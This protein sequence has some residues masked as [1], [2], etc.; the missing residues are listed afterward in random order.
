V[1]ISRRTAL[2]G[3]AAAAGAGAL[4]LGGSS[5][6]A[7]AAA[8][9][10]QA[11]VRER[12]SAGLPSPQTVSSWI[13]LVNSRFGPQR[14]TGDDNHRRFVNWLDDQLSSAGFRVERDTYTFQRWSADARRDVSAWVQLSGSRERRPLD[15]LSPFAYSGSTRSTGPVTGRALYVPVGNG[16]LAQAV[17]ALL[18]AP[19]ADLAD[20]VVVLESPCQDSP[21]STVWGVDPGGLPLSAPHLSTPYQWFN[22]LG[23]TYA[24]LA[25]HCR[26]L[27]YCWTNVSDERARWVYAPPSMA[28][29][30]ATIPA[31]WVGAGTAATLR[32]LSAQGATIGIRLDAQVYPHTATDTLIATLPGASDEVMAIGSHTDGVNI[33]EENGA[34]AVLALGLQAARVP[35]AHRPRSLALYLAT[36]HFAGAALTDPSTATGPYGKLGADASGA[37]R[38]HPEIVSK[39]VV[40]LAA[41]HLGATEWAET[42][43]GFGPTGLP[44]A[45]HWYVGS[46]AAGTTTAPD[47]ANQVIADVTLAAGAG[48]PARLLRMQVEKTGQASPE[49]LPATTNAI[50][51]MGLIPVPD[52][53]VTAAPNGEIDKFDLNIMYT[54]VKILAAMAA[55]LNGLSAQQIAGV[56]PLPPTLRS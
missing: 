17:T 33:V 45:Q 11:P 41:E 47:S 37:W 35:Q 39:T 12:L 30:T 28:P 50:P 20:C 55:T 3:L 19:P 25:G 40:A 44:E 31:V 10:R 22:P 42:S 56:A 48:Y 43:R 7:Y 2:T 46:K 54:E 4:S 32:A 53:M 21:A 9:A 51:S 29:S 38:D 6:L 1:E 49:S 26:G 36:G 52:Y 34:L 13:E 15:V 16:T 27:V 5:G 24:E 18:A 14:L 23:A 8:A